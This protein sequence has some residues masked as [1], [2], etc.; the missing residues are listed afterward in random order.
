MA[1]VLIVGGV[2]LFLG[3]LEDVV[4]GD[5][6]VAADVYIHHTLQQIRFPLLD[7]IM[8]AASELGDAAVTLPLVFVTLGWFLWHGELRSAIYWVAAVALAQVFVA[9]LKFVVH[10]PRPTL[11]YE[12]V[13]SFSFPSNHATLSVVVYGFLAFFVARAFHGAKR[14]WT[15]AVTGL[16][17]AVIAVSRLY[18]GV[19]WFSDVL[20]GISFGIA[21]IVMAAL[22][23]HVGEGKPSSPSL[24]GAVA[25]MTFLLSAAVHLVVQYGADL[26]RYAPR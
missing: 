20:A 14:Q 24:L 23:H 8:V 13:Q 4:S 15:V 16:L 11:I 18:L 12:G 25:V 2:W 6:L 9:T 10:R 3:I 5:P 26:I 1:S 21:W 19:H 17:I 22:L 7:A